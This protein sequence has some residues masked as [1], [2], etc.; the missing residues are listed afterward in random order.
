MLRR[1]MMSAALVGMLFAAAG[2][3]AE[4]FVSV[5]DY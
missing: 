1:L 2:A 4:Q 5:G 3:H